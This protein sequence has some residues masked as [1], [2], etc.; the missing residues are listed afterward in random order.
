MQRLHAPPSPALWRTFLARWAPLGAVAAVALAPLVWKPTP[1]ATPATAAVAS[2]P[3]EIAIPSDLNPAEWIEILL[4]SD[5]LL[6]RASGDLPERD[7]ET[8]SV[9]DL[10]SAL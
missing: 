6:L 8:V 5:Y 3:A 2:P 1:A 10:I 4:P 7:S 9:A